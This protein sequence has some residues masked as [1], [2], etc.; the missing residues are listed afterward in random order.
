MQANAPSLCVRGGLSDKGGDQLHKVRDPRVFVVGLPSTSLIYT[1][2]G[3]VKPPVC[4]FLNC[5]LIVV[6]ALTLVVDS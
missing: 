4:Q 6:S 2:K 5:L 3:G 1:K